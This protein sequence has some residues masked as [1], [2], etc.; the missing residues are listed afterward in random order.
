[1]VKMNMI[2]TCP[3]PKRSA[4]TAAPQTA[5]EARTARKEKVHIVKH[6]MDLT[7]IARRTMTH[8]QHDETSI[9]NEGQ[10]KLAPRLPPQ[11][12]R[13]LAVPCRLPLS[14]LHSTSITLHSLSIKMDIHSN[15]YLTVF[16]SLT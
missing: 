14:P 13:R 3:S 2:Q 6:A 15:K 4:G 7:G 16:P 1:M 11:R 8:G 5:V 12:Q 9:N 10:T